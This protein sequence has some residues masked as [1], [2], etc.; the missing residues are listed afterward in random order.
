V[1]SL[2]DALGGELTAENRSD[3]PGARFSFSVPVWSSPP[4]AST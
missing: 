1:R 4:P 2:V 3:G